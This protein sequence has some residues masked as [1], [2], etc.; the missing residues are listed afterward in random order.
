MSLQIVIA[1]AGPL[2]GLARI[3]SLQLL[4]QLFGHVYITAT[5]HAEIL[6]QAGLFPDMRTLARTMAEGWIEIADEP[7]E[8]RPRLNPG[9]DIGE[10]SAIDLACHWQEQGKPVLL[11]MDDRA[12]RLEAKTAGIPALGTAGVI[13]L[14]KEMG[15]IPDARALLMQL[16][17]AGFYLSEKHIDIILRSVGE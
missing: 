15:L 12:G 4:Q 10:A 9:V 8:K 5:I 16:K 7:H 1:D 11:I 6:P 13:G 3:D 2:I 17:Q 14:A